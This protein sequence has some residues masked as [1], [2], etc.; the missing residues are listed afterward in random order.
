MTITGQILILEGS[1]P[2]RGRRMSAIL[3]W[4]DDFVTNRLLL[5][6]PTRLAIAVLG[7]GRSGSDLRVRNLRY[8][9]EIPEKGALPGVYG[10]RGIR[11]RVAGKVYLL[12]EVYPLVFLRIGCCWGVPDE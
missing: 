10:F 1:G 11:V 9:R 12:Y 2:I 8:R 6:S 4:G 3:E 7:F 5:R